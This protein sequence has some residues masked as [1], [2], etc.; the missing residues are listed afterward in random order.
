M[1]AQHSYLKGIPSTHVPAKRKNLPRYG[2]QEVHHIQKQQIGYARI[3]VKEN[4]FEYYK[5]EQ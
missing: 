2:E 1:Y 5:V 4:L 3:P